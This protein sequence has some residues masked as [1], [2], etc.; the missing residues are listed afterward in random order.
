ME[1]LVEEVNMPVIWRDGSVMEQCT[2]FTGAALP[3]PQQA[4]RASPDYLHG[5]SVLRRGGGRRL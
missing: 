4:G 1:N 5:Y 2:A 3:V